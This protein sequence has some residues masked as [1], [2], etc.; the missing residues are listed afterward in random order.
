MLPVVVV[1][2]PKAQLRLEVATTPAQQERG[3]MGRTS[4]A[5]QA[6]MLFVFER[7]GPVAFWMKNTLL[8]LDMIFVAADGTVR[9]VIADVATVPANLPDAQIPLEKGVAKYVIELGAGEA[10]RDGI[11][12]RTRLNI[13]STRP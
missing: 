12:P 5:P 4:L 8:P 10:V 2:A 7:D 9:S 1:A 6:G 3:L 11:A 13:P